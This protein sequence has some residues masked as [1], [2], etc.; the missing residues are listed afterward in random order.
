[1][2]DPKYKK[3]FIEKKLTFNA[4]N[5]ELPPIVEPPPLDEIEDL[6][7]DTHR[8][9]HGITN[10]DTVVNLAS[11]EVEEYEFVEWYHGPDRVEL[12]RQRQ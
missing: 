12:R 9:H 6:I 3:D 10:L 4:N 8:P 1:M 2:Y 7:Y 11:W 5:H